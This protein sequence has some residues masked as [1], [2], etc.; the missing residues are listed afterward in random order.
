[1]WGPTSR[2]KGYVFAVASYPP[3]S[4]PPPPPG[5]GP[6]NAYGAPPGQYF[7]PMRTTNGKATAALVCGICAFF[8]CPLTAIAAVIL[9]PQA[10]RE[11]DASPQTQDGR[12]LAEAAHILGWIGCGWLVL[13]ILT[14][15][16]FLIIPLVFMGTADTMS[17]S[18]VIS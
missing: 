13:W 6:P 7:G 18:L 2:P 15:V 10:K 17:L 12:G 5:Y 1:M 4:A 3:A 8:V 11:I 9:A 16:G 14:F